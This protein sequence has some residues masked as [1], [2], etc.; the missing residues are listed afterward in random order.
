M[1]HTLAAMI[2]LLALTTALELR[3][4]ALNGTYTVA[5]GNPGNAFD[6]GDIGTFFDDLETHG[7][8]GAV[9]LDVF[10][11][12]GAF[13]STLSFAL[14]VDGIGSGSVIRP[15]SGL[16]LTSSLTIRA[17]PGHNPIVIGSGAHTPKFG[18]GN[19]VMAFYNVGYLTVEGLTLRGGDRFGLYILNDTNNDMEYIRVARCRIH[20]IVRG[21]AIG[22][23]STTGLFHN[24]VIENNK[25]WPPFGSSSQTGSGIISSQFSG[26]EWSVRHN[27][28]VERN[29]VNRVFYH[30]PG[31]TIPWSEF[32]NNIIDCDGIA[33]ALELV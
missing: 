4:Q 22:V 11:T 28:V 29:Q 10:D 5:N 30:G 16:S 24:V 19:G 7:V 8:G 20:N 17:V 6:Y 32:E 31:T 26:N 14:G 13:T 15:V 12:G 21:G 18:G 2:M 23:M 3:C 33:Y 27:T 1:S 25:C 9:T